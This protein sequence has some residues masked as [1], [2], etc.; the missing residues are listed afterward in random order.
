MTDFKH[1]MNN[2]DEEMAWQRV[3]AAQQNALGFA[4]LPIDHMTSEQ[5]KEH[6]KAAWESFREAQ[7]ARDTYHEQF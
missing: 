3:V 5:L 4:R 1:P 7:N 2:F 6:T